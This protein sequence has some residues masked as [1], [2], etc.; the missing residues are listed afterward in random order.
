[1]V[2]GQLLHFSPS[3]CGYLEI[4]TSDIEIGLY[5]VIIYQPEQRK[6]FQQIKYLIIHTKLTGWEIVEQNGQTWDRLMLRRDR[7]VVE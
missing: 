4:D 3:E 7:P 6:R 5:D 2:Y 1:M